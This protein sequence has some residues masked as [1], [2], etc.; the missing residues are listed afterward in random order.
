LVCFYKEISG[1]PENKCGFKL[2][3]GIREAICISSVNPSV[4]WL[5]VEF[6]D[7]TKVWIMKKWRLATI[8]FTKQ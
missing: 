6:E 3:P 8:N 5:S 2:L 7:M 1:N 4:Q